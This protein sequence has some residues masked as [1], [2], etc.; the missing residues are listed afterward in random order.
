MEDGVIVQMRPEVF[1]AITPAP[2]WWTGCSEGYQ[3]VKRRIEAG[4]PVDVP[5]LHVFYDRIDHEG[6]HRALAA[7]RLGFETIPVAVLKEAPTENELA[8]LET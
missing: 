5:Y 3:R 6:R 2:D 8:D 4:D 1:L 7:K